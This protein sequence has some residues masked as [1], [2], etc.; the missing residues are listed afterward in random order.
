MLKNSV[1]IDW[2]VAAHQAARPAAS[3]A[4]PGA[5]SQVWRAP[6]MVN[7]TEPT[8]NVIASA[9]APTRLA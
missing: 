1:P 8:K 3:A 6:P 9:V 2:I 7:S 5:A 4:L